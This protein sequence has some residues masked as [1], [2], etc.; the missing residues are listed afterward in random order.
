MPR[1]AAAES[2]RDRRAEILAAALDVFAEQGFA[3]AR[4]DDVA[5]KAGVAKGTLYLHFASKQDLF[6]KLVSGEAAPVLGQL[7]GL[8]RHAHGPTIELVAALQAIFVREVL[9]TRRKDIVRLVIS[10]GPRFPAIAQFWHR[11][12]VSKGLAVLS[13]LARRAAARGEIEGDALVR[14]PHLFMAPLLMAMIWDGLFSPF[15]PLDVPALL[16]AHRQVLFPS[17]GTKP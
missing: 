17:G 13:A 14:F 1:R 8:V 11:E 3:A 5:A 7:E 6:E 2:Q 9:G 4:L 15:A 10:E 16:Q 12:V